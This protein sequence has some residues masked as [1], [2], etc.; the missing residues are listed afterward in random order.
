M[1]SWVTPST[2][3]RAERT[4]A[5]KAYAEALKDRIP[6]SFFLA[7]DEAL[8]VVLGPVRN[9]EDICALGR[10]TVSHRQPLLVI[11]DDQHRWIGTSLFAGNRYDSDKCQRIVA[12]WKARMASNTGSAE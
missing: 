9:V 7:I 11:V 2:E 6:A 5:V 1:S 10:E 8:S 12:A 4:E 3:S